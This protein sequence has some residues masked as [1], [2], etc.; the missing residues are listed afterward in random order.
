VPQV[1][2]EILEL[3]DRLEL[4]VRL[5]DRAQIQQSATES[6]LRLCAL[7]RRAGLRRGHGGRPRLRYSLEC[8][9]LV[10]G[11]SL[12]GLDEVGDEVP[13]PL[14]LDVDVRPSFT[15]ALA[16]RDQAV[17]EADDKYDDERD[18]NERDQDLQVV[19][20]FR[21]AASSI[22]TSA[23]PALLPAAV[24][25]PFLREGEHARPAAA[26]TCVRAASAQTCDRAQ[27]RSARAPRSRRPAPNPPRPRS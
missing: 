6:G 10:R 26:G 13:A 25:A 11:V 22:M 3:L 12:D 24:D 8:L 27:R 17:V 20:P 19:L 4:R 18:D 7:L 14:Q 5:S 21:A 15:H 2:R 1:L 16:H 9:S 23:E